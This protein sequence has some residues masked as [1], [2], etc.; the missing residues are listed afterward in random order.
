MKFW[1]IINYCIFSFLFFCC[2]LIFFIVA[3]GTWFTAYLAEAVEPALCCAILTWI[4][5][6]RIIKDTVRQIEKED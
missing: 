2:Y 6:Q 5:T 3:F 1:D 4:F